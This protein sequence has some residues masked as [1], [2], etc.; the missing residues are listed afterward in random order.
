MTTTM[1]TQYRQ[2][3]LLLLV[4]VL[5]LNLNLLLIQGTGCVAEWIEPSPRSREVEGSSPARAKP[6]ALTLVLDVSSLEAQD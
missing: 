1:T 2:L 5:V 3:I 6:K 4:L